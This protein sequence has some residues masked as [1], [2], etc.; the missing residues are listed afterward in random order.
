MRCV[1]CTILFS[2]FTFLK[3]KMLFDLVFLS[4]LMKISYTP[5]YTNDLIFDSFNI[6]KL[7]Y[8]RVRRDFNFKFN[9]Y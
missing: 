5:M 2:I 6:F 8:H 1:H 4:V 3:L 7:F 9:Y